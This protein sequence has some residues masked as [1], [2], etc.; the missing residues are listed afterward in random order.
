MVWYVRRH[1]A[2]VAM[3]LATDVLICLVCLFVLFPAGF[4]LN[5]H[6]RPR[7]VDRQ[8]SIF[9]SLDGEPVAD[10]VGRPVSSE[11]SDRA[12]DGSAVAVEAPVVSSAPV[13]DAVPV[14]SHTVPVTLGTARDGLDPGLQDAYDAILVGCVNLE[15][16]IYVSCDIDGARKAANAVLLDHPEIY[17]SDGTMS[18]SSSSRDDRLAVMVD[19]VP[20]SGTAT[21]ELSE[22]DAV[23]DSLVGSSA[24]G[25]EYDVAWSAYVNLAKWCS[26]DLEAD[27]SQSMRSALIGRSSVCAGYARAFQYA[28]H[29]HGIRCGLVTG[30]F[31][32]ERHMWCVA[33]LDGEWCQIDPTWGDAE[34]AGLE[35]GFD[36]AF[37]PDYFGM[38]DDDVVASGHVLEPGQ[39]VPTCSSRANDPFERAGLVVDSRDQSRVGSLFWGQVDSGSVTMRFVGDDVRAWA[40]TGLADGT[41]LGKELLSLAEE[42]GVVELQYGIRSDKELGILQIVV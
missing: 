31:A 22:M 20:D 10:D 19:S 6:A 3:C 4:S 27:D 33:C 14:A 38:T 16:P 17:W 30:D 5:P 35:S 21:R 15:F 12:D 24:D 18:I 25:S 2:V 32:G 40:M 34:R 11:R 13:A 8:M 29:R 26:Y 7:S 37:V 1:V 42:R 39:S 41:L 9:D 23:V 36:I 28:L